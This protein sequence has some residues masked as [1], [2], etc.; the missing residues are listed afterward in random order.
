METG[1]E[2]G[3]ENV[4]D[5]APGPSTQKEAD[6]NEA[7]QETSRKDESKSY[8]VRENSVRLILLGD[9][10]LREAHFVPKV[11]AQ[12]RREKLTD[13]RMGKVERMDKWESKD[14]PWADGYHLT[15]EY[16]AQ[17]RDLIKDCRNQATAL[18]LSI[19][20]NDLRRNP[21]MGTV[22]H[23]VEGLRTILQQ[24]QEIPGVVLYLLSPIPCSTGVD[25]LRD[26]LQEKM[27]E[28]IQE[29]HKATEGRAFF[30]NLTR[31]KD[32]LIAK[33]KGQYHCNKYWADNKHLNK[34]GAELLVDELIRVQGMT[35]SRHFMADED[36]WERK[37]QRPQ[38]SHPLRGLP[39]PRGGG[40][41]GQS[42]KEG[43]GTGG[44]SS[45]EPSP[46]RTGKGG[47][48]KG[49]RRLDAREIIDR[50]RRGSALERL[51]TP[52]DKRRRA[53]TRTPERRRSRTRSPE[54]R[55]QRNRSPRREYP[56]RISYGCCCA[57][58]RVHG[59]CCCS[60]GPP[61]TCRLR[62]RT[63]ERRDRHGDD[64]D[65]GQQGHQGHYYG[66]RQ[67]HHHRRHHGRHV[68]PHHHRR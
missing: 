31:E 65:K 61:P 53:R 50:K 67:E 41:R 13:P 7:G 21:C 56:H 37:G 57:Q 14:A 5:Q 4:N 19:G 17:I 18:V 62:S 63:P 49:I 16:A 29:F 8:K 3:K 45:Y 10:H 66:H 40:S 25:Q 55:R 15:S 22:D 1:N 34:R 39:R 28:L 20:T 44:W 48:Y 23:L 9:S 2:A 11:Y 47:P 35:A 59:H 36:V 12:R 54:S 51:G 30:I 27:W 52:P 43:E 32:P 46:K 38:G 60:Y 68:V 33:R 6:G 24:L 64:D 26:Q 42:R 58:Y